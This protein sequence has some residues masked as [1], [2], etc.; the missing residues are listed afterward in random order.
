MVDEV[1]S[2][3]ADT[4]S[5]RRS[6][7]EARAAKGAVEEARKEAGDRVKAAEEKAKL[8][9]EKLS[10]TEDWARKAEQDAEE[11]ETSQWE[12]AESMNKAE[13]D[14]AS[15]QAEHE[16]Y[17]E[18]ALPAARAKRWRNISNPR[19][20]RLA[21]SPNTKRESEEITA[22]EA[23]E[24]GEV[25]GT[26]PLPENI[27]VLNDPGQPDVPEQAV[28][29]EQ[30]VPT[31][32]PDDD[33]P[34]TPALCLG[35]CSGTSN[36]GR[37][38]VVGPNS[39]FREPQELSAKADVLGPARAR[40]I[41]IGARSWDLTPCSGNHRSCL[42]RQMSWVLFG[43]VQFWSGWFMSDFIPGSRG[44]SRVASP[45]PRTYSSASACLQAISL[46]VSSVQLST[47]TMA[48]SKRSRYFS[49]VSDS[50]CL[51]PN[52]WDTPSFLVFELRKVVAK[53][54]ASFLKQPIDPGARLRYH[55]RAAPVKVR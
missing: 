8:A 11:A 49:S 37:C 44:C 52:K 18:V 40:P 24:E 3:E 26:A 41:M 51:T 20:S 17:L 23:F 39:V 46:R 19:T 33:Q 7:K 55:W 10:F 12:M 43:H 54:S 50:P 28:A 14:L 1:K 4:R 13:R 21:L 29:P 27:V 25:L 9:E 2:A 47:Y 48:L 53:E 22:E 30:P 15:A 34:T 35:S 45:R 36:S 6:E 42:R 5:A 31:V 32:Q 16:R 38:P